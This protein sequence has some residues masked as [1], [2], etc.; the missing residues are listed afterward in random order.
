M[1]GDNPA[2]YPTPTGTSAGELLPDIFGLSEMFGMKRGSSRASEQ[3]AVKSAEDEEVAW[4]VL[5][6]SNERGIFFSMTLV[7]SFDT[8]HFHAGHHSTF[9]HSE[10]PASSCTPLGSFFIYDAHDFAFIYS[11]RDVCRI[12]CLCNRSI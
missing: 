9:K 12:A 5:D 8:D 4:V 6:M 11:S 1:S 2:T 10:D 3:D 7:Y